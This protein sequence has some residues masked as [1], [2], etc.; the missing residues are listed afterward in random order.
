MAGY[1]AKFEDSFFFSNKKCSF[2]RYFL[3]TIKFRISGT[4]NRLLYRY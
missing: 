4:G 3:M 1:L 2:F